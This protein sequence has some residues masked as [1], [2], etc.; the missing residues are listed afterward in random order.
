MLTTISTGRSSGFPDLY[1]PSHPDMNSG[2]LPVKALISDREIRITAAG[3][4]L[5]LTG[6]P[7]KLI[8]PETENSF[9]ESI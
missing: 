9:T 3:P 1:Q 6:F 5:S 7:F 4:L 8:A 2:M